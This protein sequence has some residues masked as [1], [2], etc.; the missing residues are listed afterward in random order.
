MGKFVKPVVWKVARVHLERIFHGKC[1]YCE[2]LYGVT[3]PADIE[4]FRPKTLYP[5]LTYAWDN[6]LPA[7]QAC[8]RSKGARFPLAEGS[9]KATREGEE[10]LEKR[11]LLDPCS[12]HPREHLVFNDNGLVF[13]DTPQGLTT[14][15]TLSLNRSALVVARKEVA[16]RVRNLISLVMTIPSALSELLQTMQ[17]SAPYAAV[18]RQLFKRNEGTLRRLDLESLPERDRK[19]LELYLGQAPAKSVKKAAKAS[20]EHETKVESFT[21]SRKTAGPADKSA[22]E[23]YFAKR[24]TIERISVENFKVLTKLDVNLATDPENPS[25]WMVLLGENSTGKST[26]LKAI[27]LTVMGHEQRQQVQG[28]YGVTPDL[29]LTY[30]AAAGRVRIWLSGVSRPLELS[31]ERGAR[32]FKGEP[33]DKV[34][35]LGYGSTRLLPRQNMPVEGRAT[36]GAVRVSNLFDPVARLVDAERWLSNLPRKLFLAAATVLEAVLPMRANDRL[37]VVTRAGKRRVVIRMF[38]HETPLC[39]LSDGYQAIAALVTDVLS[40]LLPVW[41]ERVS[42]AEGIV[43]IDELDAHLHPTWRKRI[44]ADLRR[45]LPH[46]QFISTTHDP[47]CIQG[48]KKGEVLVLRRSSANRVAAVKELPSPEGMTPDQILTSEH[49]GLKSTFDD[50]TA[51]LF[52]EYYSLLSARSLTQK[53]KARLTALK[54]QL[55]TRHYMGA[56]RREQLMLEA[57][58]RYLASK[59]PVDGQAQKSRRDAIET[60]LDEIYRASEPPVANTRRASRRKQRGARRLPRPTRT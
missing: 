20:A 60:E 47:L 32:N 22:R 30:G 8:N 16:S 42:M 2:S 12:E 26:L 13:S 19:Q 55:R 23:R 50:A 33:G 10:H 5:W 54:T 3:S 11:L 45:C 6:L 36:T 46:V 29:V 44:V 17:D 39:D 37:K 28:Q 43:L 4:C 49:F 25:S 51:K 48:L 18:A 38:G 57:I 21:L 7:C 58:D 34:L 15:D 53:Q 24:R 40:V 27:A 9:P 31:Y 14:I 56:T 52:D 35:L 1:A 59:P 41:K